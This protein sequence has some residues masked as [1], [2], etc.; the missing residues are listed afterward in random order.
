MAAAAAASLAAPELFD[1]CGLRRGG[2]GLGTRFFDALEPAALALD[3]FLLTS[4]SVSLLS[5]KMLLYLS[6]VLKLSALDP[7]LFFEDSCSARDEEVPLVIDDE[8]VGV[9]EGFTEGEACDPGDDDAAM[10]AFLAC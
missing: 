3:F 6:T 5:L 1:F 8:V 7:D 2:L 10:A 9:E 4:E